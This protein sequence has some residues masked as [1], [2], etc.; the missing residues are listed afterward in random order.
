MAV[1]LLLELL[2]D[3]LLVGLFSLSLS[4]S[5][6]LHVHVC[7]CART[8]VCVMYMCVCARICLAHRFVNTLGLPQ[9]YGQ[10]SRNWGLFACLRC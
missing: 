7:V 5:L 8:H 10:N 3:P 2:W 4:L 1:E 6:P 9:Y